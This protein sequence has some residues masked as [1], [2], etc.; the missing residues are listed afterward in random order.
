MSITLSAKAGASTL[1]RGNMEMMD[2]TELYDY[3]KSFLNVEAVNFPRWNEDLRNSNF[4]WFKLAKKTGSTQDYNITLNGGSQTVQSMFTMGYF[5]EESAV[6]GYDL[7]RYSTRIK[8]IY[9]PYEWL[10]IKP[11]LSGS[12]TTDK[13]RQYSVGA[14]YSMLPWD[15]PYDEN[16]NPGAQL[17]FGMGQLKGYQLPQRPCCGQRILQAAR[18]ICREDSTLTSRLLPWLTFSSVTIIATTTARLT[19]T[20]TLSRAVARV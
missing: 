6:K 3:Y 20:P 2:V 4:D 12:R 17:L 5:K 8:V 19:A 11:N 1:S 9:K 18:T 7:S 15:N 16:G 14:M 13:D 10:S